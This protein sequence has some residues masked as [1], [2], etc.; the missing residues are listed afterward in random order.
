[1][2]RYTVKNYK[3]NMLESVSKFQK[4]HPK[5]KIVE[6]FEQDDLL[7]LSTEPL[8]GVMPIDDPIAQQE[9]PVQEDACASLFEF[10]SRLLQFGVEVHLWHLNCSRNAQHLA[11]KE[12]YEACD[13]AGD[14]LLEALIGKYGRP[15]A[16]A[17]DCYCDGAFTDSSISKI[18][19]VKDEAAS[20][21]DGIDPGIDN[22]LS[23]F[24]EVCN[25]VIYKLKRL[26]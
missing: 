24:V 13:D 9:A 26:A 3:G 4:S 19:A 16:C 18:V 12:L 7:R 15:A 6:A 21:V 23:D 25:S 1:M 20:F 5:M 14:K 22:I 11:L 17:T 8:T 10:G 2:K